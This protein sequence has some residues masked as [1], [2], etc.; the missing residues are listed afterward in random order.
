MANDKAIET[1]GD[2]TQILLP[3][4]AV[5]MSLFKSDYQGFRQYLYSWMLSMCVTYTLKISV[6]ETRPNG[7]DWSFPS[8]HTM[9]AFTGSSY[10]WR[11]YS[12]WYGVPA[13]L[14]ASFTGYS[15]V[16]SNNHYSWDVV[17]GAAI[18]I[19]ANLIFTTPYKNHVTLSALSGGGLQVS[20]NYPLA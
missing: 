14:V 2:Y 20:L 13:T 18:G 9:A 4:A 7:G 6:N 12:A 10:L 15:R 17:A 3:A 5:S 11:R 19:G 1:A 8:G 16:E